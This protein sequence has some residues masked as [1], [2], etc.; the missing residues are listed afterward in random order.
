MDSTNEIQTIT[1]S[2][3]T[4]KLTKGGSVLLPSQSSANTSIQ[5]LVLGF[6][7]DTTWTCPAGVTSITIEAWGAGGG[8]GTTMSG[9]PCGCSGCGPSVHDGLPGGK[10][11]YTKSIISVNPGTTYPIVIGQGGCSN[12]AGGN[13]LFNNVVFAEGGGGATNSS[14]ACNSSWV[15]V[16][17]AQGTTGANGSVTNWIYDDLYYSTTPSYIPQNLISN[18]VQ[19]SQYSLAQGGNGKS[20]CANSQG[21]DGFLVIKY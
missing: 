17:T 13:T 18:D 19:Y 8:G 6:D 7:T 3:D 9:P 10:G 15:Y 20:G 16:Q 11:G 14:Y 2:G 1:I 21:E 4:L 5:S 12:Q